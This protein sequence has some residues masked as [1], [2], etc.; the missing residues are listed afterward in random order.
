MDG[1][2]ATK[3]HPL[4]SLKCPQHRLGEPEYQYEHH[5][6]ETTQ[7]MINAR[8]TWQKTTSS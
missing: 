2:S 5:E 4:P 1:V 7:R 3:L 8:T 6:I